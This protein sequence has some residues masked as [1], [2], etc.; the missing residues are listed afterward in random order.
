MGREYCSHTPRVVRR[1]E[2]SG[3]LTWLPLSSRRRGVESRDKDL[4]SCGPRAPTSLHLPPS[5]HAIY[6]DCGRQAFRE[7]GR[8]RAATSGDEKSDCGASRDVRNKGKGSR[9]WE[10]RR[11]RHWLAFLSILALGLWALSPFETHR[12]RF[13]IGRVEIT[14][15]KLEEA[16]ERPSPIVVVG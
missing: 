4:G 13:Y 10:I 7:H 1:G 3:K 8:K 14:G 5:L 12:A 9:S 16:I 6:H 2:P 11:A 15:R